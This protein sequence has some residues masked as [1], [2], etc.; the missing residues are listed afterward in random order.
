MGHL[1]CDNKSGMD[2]MGLTYTKKDRYHTLFWPRR[3]SAIDRSIWGGIIQTWQLLARA[4][5]FWRHNEPRNI[6]TTM[7]TD[8]HHDVFTL[9]SSLNLHSRPSLSFVRAEGGTSGIFRNQDED[10]IQRKGLKFSALFTN[11]VLSHMCI[12]P[13]DLLR[14]CTLQI[15]GIRL[16]GSRSAPYTTFHSP[17]SPNYAARHLPSRY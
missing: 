14:F 8:D 12:V 11:Y 6:N 16:Y 7:V 3:I 5:R 2:L 15:L 10:R 13:E 17:F 9:T 1:T 4:A